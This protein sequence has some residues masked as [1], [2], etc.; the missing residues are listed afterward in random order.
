MKYFQKFR[1]TII[2]EFS[3]IQIIYSNIDNVERSHDL[4]QILRTDS[5][6]WISSIDAK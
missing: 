1:N 3:N 2:S 4:W 5:I 6:K